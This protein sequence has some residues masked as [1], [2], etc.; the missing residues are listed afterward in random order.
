[1]CVFFSNLCMYATCLVSLICSSVYLQMIY[2]F[3]FSWSSYPGRI[4]PVLI[5]WCFTGLQIDLYTS[6]VVSYTHKC[7]IF[8]PGSK[9][10]ICSCFTRERHILYDHF[11]SSLLFS[12]DTVIFALQWGSAHW[13]HSKVCGRFRQNRRTRQD[14]EALWSWWLTFTWGCTGIPGRIHRLSWLRYPLCVWVTRQGVAIYCH[15]F[16]GA[17]VNWLCL[18]KDIISSFVDAMI[19]FMQVHLQQ[20]DADCDFTIDK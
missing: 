1:M 11:W 18:Q 9:W 19:L 3:T 8:Q 5:I 6:A 2:R 10:E 4:I 16:I 7:L 14:R 12:R 15:S 20:S 13:R 17:G